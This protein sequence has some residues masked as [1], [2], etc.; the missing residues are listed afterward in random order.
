[1]ISLTGRERCLVPRYAKSKHSLERGVGMDGLDLGWEK[2]FL[3]YNKRRLVMDVFF[4]QLA[5][6]MLNCLLIAIKFA[7]A[8]SAICQILIN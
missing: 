2:V 7:L 8:E 1:M 5:L 4:H 6:E 3:N